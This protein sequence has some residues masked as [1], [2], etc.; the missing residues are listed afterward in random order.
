M[1]ES[2]NTTLLL[3]YSTPTGWVQKILRLFPDK[4]PNETE[5]NYWTRLVPYIALGQDGI[6][7][8]TFMLEI[9]Q[10]AQS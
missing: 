9:V 5:K 6:G 1:S 10:D 2:Y 8:A 7:N 4:L 3:K